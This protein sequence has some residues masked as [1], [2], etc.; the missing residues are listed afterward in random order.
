MRAYLATLDLDA[1]RL[2]D[3]F[4][5]VDGEGQVSIDEFVRGAMRLKGVAST[6]DVAA[7]AKE[8]SAIMSRL[9]ALDAAVHSNSVLLAATAAGRAEE[10]SASPRRCLR[11]PCCEEV[12]LAR[13]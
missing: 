8:S 12:G 4:S 13:L 3:L 1:T 10:V 6:Q 5:H 2:R 9:D 11:Q 7:L